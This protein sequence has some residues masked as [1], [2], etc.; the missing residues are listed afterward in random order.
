[1]IRASSEGN[2][3]VATGGARE[4]GWS[5]EGLYGRGMAAA[6]EALERRQSIH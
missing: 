5:V 2:S 6:E 3:Q 1:M 4:D